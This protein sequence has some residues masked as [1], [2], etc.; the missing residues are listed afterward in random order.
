M[1][2]NSMKIQLEYRLFYWTYDPPLTKKGQDK[3]KG[4]NHYYKLRHLSTKGEEPD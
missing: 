3:K 1:L 4:G 2:N